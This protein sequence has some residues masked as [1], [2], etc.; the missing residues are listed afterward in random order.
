[1]TKPGGVFS[2]LHLHLGGAI[3]PH[4]LYVRLK[5]DG[6]PLLKRFPT[7][8]SFERFFH[9]RRHNLRDYL[10]MHELVESIQQPAAPPLFYLVTGLV[11][12]ASFFENLAYRGRRHTPYLR[13]DADL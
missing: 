4:I 10:R 5:R 6:H 13:T 8:Q 7:E 9:R 2:E 1:M 12:G 3:L 11:R